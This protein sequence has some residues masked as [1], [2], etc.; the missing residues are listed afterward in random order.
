MFLAAVCV[1][2]FSCQKP[3]QT[4][5]LS[6]TVE[7]GQNAPMGDTYIPDE[8][9]TTVPVLIKYLTGNS[10]EKVTVSIKGLPAD[11]VVAQDTFSQV[12]TYRADFVFITKHAAHGTYPV[13]LT[14]G[15]RTTTPKTVTF[16]LTVRS[17]DCAAS[18]LGDHSANN[19][20]TARKF[21]YT[22]TAVAAGVP[23][24]LFIKNLGGYGAVTSTHVVLNPNLNTFTIPSQNIGNGVIMEGNGTFTAN[25]MKIFYNVTY[26]SGATPESCNAA[27]TKM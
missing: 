15:S 10:E 12:P 11:I 3:S 6:Y 17:A 22:A 16:N 1:V 25:A 14:S 26:T 13:T 18:L 20:C 2:T 19:E 4:P 7:N 27:L 24:E 8:G 23:N 5:P 21:P 9:N